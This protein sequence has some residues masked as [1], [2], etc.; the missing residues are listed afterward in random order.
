MS[1]LNIHKCETRPFRHGG[2][3]ESQ[4]LRRENSKYVGRTDLDLFDTVI[5]L[6]SKIGGS[7]EVNQFPAH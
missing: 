7:N 3:V 2:F 1:K 4:P 6:L 5:H